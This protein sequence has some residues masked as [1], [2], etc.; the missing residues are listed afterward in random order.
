ML[1]SATTLIEGEVSGQTNPID[2][3]IVELSFDGQLAGHF[4][5]VGISG[6]AGFRTLKTR[7]GF[8]AYGGIGLTA[9]AGGRAKVGVQIELAPRMN[10]IYIF[11][12]SKRP[13]ISLSTPSLTNYMKIRTRLIIQL[14][15]LSGAITACAS[16]MKKSES[17]EDIAKRALDSSELLSVL[18]RC[19]TDNFFTSRLG[20][21]YI[22]E[23][24]NREAISVVKPAL[25]RS[26]EQARELHLILGT[27]FVNLGQTENAREQADILVN[28]HPESHLGYGLKAQVEIQKN[29]IEDALNYLAISINKE[30]STEAY[31]LMT[32]LYYQKED[33]KRSAQA[34][35]KAIAFGYSAIDN[36]DAAV[37][38]TISLTA[39]G[40]VKE[41][42]QIID[43][44]IDRNPSNH[45]DR[46]VI[47]AKRYLSQNEKP[48]KAL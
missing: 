21:F 23:D 42:K 3:G 41:A 14:M 2:L 8:A 31:E 20:A 4:V 28:K 19:K 43:A 39:L 48:S 37:A 36:L 26:E 45:E 16:D 5:G 40:F 13:Q 47:E 10:D 11:G 18:E 24:K 46:A 44:H 25:A 27:A 9:F 32:I 29:N 6:E 15:V 35:Q 7:P 12:R 38:S 30:P 22:R 1:S 34:M 33:Y 17:C